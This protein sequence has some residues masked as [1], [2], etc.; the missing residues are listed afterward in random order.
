MNRETDV[1]GSVTG[2]AYSKSQIKLIYILN[3]NYSR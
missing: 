2:E 1:Y 3:E